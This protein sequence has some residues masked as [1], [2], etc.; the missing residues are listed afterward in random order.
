MLKGSGLLLAP[1]SQ[2]IDLL[3]CLVQ[4]RHP[5]SCLYSKLPASLICWSPCTQW[6]TWA[7]SLGQMCAVTAK[8]TA[9][10]D[11]SRQQEAEQHVQRH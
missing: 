1:L 3:A 4:P 5:A 2:P 8:V 6:H 10:A 7:A 9:A 11:G